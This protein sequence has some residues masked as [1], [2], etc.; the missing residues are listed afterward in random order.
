[1]RMESPFTLKPALIFVSLFT[2]IIFFTQLLTTIFGNSG[3]YFI[4]LFSGFLDVDAITLTL[5][6]MALENTIS[7][8]TA[9][10]GIFI[11]AVSNTVFK[12]G[13]AYYL[14]TSQLSK[15]VIYSFF[16]ILFVGL[17]SLFLN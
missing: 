7:N 16:V 10:S 17:L 1:M 8:S 5:S 6:K 15:L 2:I 11:A 13:I 4:A 3:L 12:G 9:A 14:G